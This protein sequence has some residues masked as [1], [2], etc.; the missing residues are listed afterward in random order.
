MIGVRALFL[1][2]CVSLISEFLEIKVE[3]K[4]RD[5]AV[6][7]LRYALMS[8]MMAKPDVEPAWV[9]GD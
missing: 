2:C 6:D 5:H 3:V 7:A 4:E 9:F 1:S 8:V